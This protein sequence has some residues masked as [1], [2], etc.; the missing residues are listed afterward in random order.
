VLP[1]AAAV[2]IVVALLTSPG[3]SPGGS[4]SSSPALGPGEPQNLGYVLVVRVPPAA[5]F[6]VVMWLEDR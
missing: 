3:L 5:G 6:A 1:G 2:W 4:T